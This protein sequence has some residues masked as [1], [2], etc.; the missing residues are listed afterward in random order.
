M[1]N[2]LTPS[3]IVALDEYTADV[4]GLLLS[5]REILPRAANGK[6]IAAS[7]A[8]AAHVLKD[9]GVGK[10]QEIRR[11]LAV[12]I[13]NLRDGVPPT[14]VRNWLRRIEAIIDVESGQYR[15]RSLVAMCRRET[16][17]QALVDLA[18]LRVVQDEHDL[19]ALLHI[20]G[21]LSSYLAIAQEMMAETQRRITLARRGVAPMSANLPAADRNGLSLVRAD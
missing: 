5:Q 19:D 9:M 18:Q 13:T 12:M 4:L 10:S 17:E 14:I 1:R 3:G 20:E 16:R 7:D 8:Y 21:E 6:P 11:M 15:P 2:S